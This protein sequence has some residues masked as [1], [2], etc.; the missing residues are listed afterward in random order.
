[1]VLNS[2]LI[3]VWFFEKETSCAFALTVTTQYLATMAVYWV[4]PMIYSASGILSYPFWVVQILSGFSLI[5]AFLLAYLDKAA[6]EDSPEDEGSHTM[7]WKMIKQLGSGFWILSCAE[8]F[9]YA[10]NLLFSRIASDYFQKRF[11]I[12]SEEAG[13]IIGLPQLIQACSAFLCG[14]LIYRSGKK[15]LFSNIFL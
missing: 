7:S 13:F 14:L 2:T 15:T 3:A 11:N 9:C 12:D 1:M 8:N 6:K 4:M 10:S 5:C